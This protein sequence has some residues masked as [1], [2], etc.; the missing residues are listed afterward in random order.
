MRALGSLNHWPRPGCQPANEAACAARSGWFHRGT[1]L[2]LALAMHGGFG[3]ASSA[4][5]TL[6]DAAIRQRVA[7]AVVLLLVEEGFGSGF[8]LN[9]QG[10]IATNQ[11]VVAGGGRIEARQDGRAALADV[12]WSSEA[13][14]LAVL[15]L[16]GDGLRGLRPLPLAVSPPAPLLDVIA[17]GFPGAANAVT[18]AS[19]PSYNE[20]NVGRVVEG[21]WGLGPLRIV[22]HSA[23][24]NPGNSGGP[25]IDACGRVIGVNT[26]GAAVS[27]STAPGGPLIDAPSGVFWAS[28]IGELADA[29]DALDIPYASSASACEVAAA[30]RTWFGAAILAG[31]I[32]A[33]ALLLAFALFR[34]NM[35]LAVERVRDG[36]SQR[37]PGRRPQE[38]RPEAPPGSVSAPRRIRIGRGRGMDVTL[39]S[40]KASR[41]HAE[42]EVAPAA[43]SS[44]PRYMLRDCNS[45]N[46]TRVF[47]K[48]RWVRIRAEA[49]QSADK[50]RFGD[51]E[52]TVAELLRR[53]G[54]SNNASGAGGGEGNHAPDHRLAGPV[55]RN[56]GTGEVMRDREDEP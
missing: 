31:A 9:S 44:K 37:R 56:P 50:V 23:D 17:V 48:G 3:Q 47:R 45:T 11:H 10:H 52:T 5:T 42:L 55:K 40:A 27:V 51:Y 35:A 34:R 49:V 1:G 2:L 46:G 36:V 25:L 6:D 29:L 33:G 38:Q 28:F 22:Q 39:P 54:A 32:A 4:A 18:A 16:R 41:L 12:V 26:G 19:A 20:G 7:P 13:L 53:A 30:E 15:R 21:T 14:D 24:I 8:V 43:Q